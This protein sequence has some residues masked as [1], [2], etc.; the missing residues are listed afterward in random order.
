M[1]TKA[2]IQNDKSQNAYYSDDQ[3]AVNVFI[4]TINMQLFL[5]SPSIKGIYTVIGQLHC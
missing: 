3:R 2:E 1:F 4:H 5:Q